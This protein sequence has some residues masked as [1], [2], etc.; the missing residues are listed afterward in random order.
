MPSASER[1]KAKLD[2]VLN[3][4]GRHDCSHRSN[5]I[6]TTRYAT[7]CGVVN[8]V[9]RRPSQ[10]SVESANGGVRNRLKRLLSLPAY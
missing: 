7:G 3:D 8:A 2:A 4:P 6:A 5:R 9:P 1:A 10:S